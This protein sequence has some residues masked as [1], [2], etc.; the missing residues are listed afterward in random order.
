MSYSAK[1]TNLDDIFDDF[2]VQTGNT[3]DS[4]RGHRSRSP[5]VDRHHDKEC[6]EEPKV[7]KQCFLVRDGERGPPGPR[8][9]RGPPGCDGKNGREGPRGPPGPKGDCG[10]DGSCGRDGACGKDAF[11]ALIAFCGCSLFIVKEHQIFRFKKGQTRS[12]HVFNIDCRFKIHGISFDGT[13]V[14]VIVIR[15]DR[16]FLIRIDPEDNRVLDPVKLDFRNN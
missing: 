16:H 9:E 10:R 6:R 15:D 7:H 14:L 5:P 4:P 11:C 8:G 12:D 3:Q 13:H 2:S 1:R